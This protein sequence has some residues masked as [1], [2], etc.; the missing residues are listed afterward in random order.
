M[1]AAA[2]DRT[3][4]RLEEG[5][6]EV[7]AIGHDLTSTIGRLRSY[8]RG[9][10]DKHLA[11]RAADERTEEILEQ[12]LLAGD[13]WEATQLERL[14]ARALAVA[15]VGYSLAGDIRRFLEVRGQQEL[16]PSER[17]S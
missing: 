6:V 11:L 8:D 17:A 9:E 10:N 14:E 4:A 15:S 16:F 1:A 2:S 12:Q 13:A 3:R 7:Q 5:A